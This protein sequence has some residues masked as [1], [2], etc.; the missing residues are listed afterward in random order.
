MMYNKW[1]KRL[2][3]PPLNDEVKLILFLTALDPLCQPD[4]TRVNH[5][6]PLYLYN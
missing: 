1:D 2:I 6:I 5:F 4:G 3:N